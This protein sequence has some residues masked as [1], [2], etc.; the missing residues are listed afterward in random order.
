MVRRFQ[1]DGR[2]YSGSVLRSVWHSL[3]VRRMQA[4]WRDWL[5][6][7]YHC[8]SYHGLALSPA[9]CAAQCDCRWEGG[10][11]S[12][13]PKTFWGK[14]AAVTAFLG[15]VV[16]LAQLCSAPNKPSSTSTSGPIIQ[17]PIW[18]VGGSTPSSRPG[19]NFID[20]SKAYGPYGFSPRTSQDG[21]AYYCCDTHQWERVCR[22]TGPAPIGRSCSCPNVGAL[23][24]FATCP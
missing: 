5:T 3:A 23:V 18:Q 1:K 11:M 17:D 12:D 9:A 8:L 21:L 16:A 7:F 15:A 2:A 19:W 20:P 4:A 14:L 10:P 22:L 13:E 6:A 24:D